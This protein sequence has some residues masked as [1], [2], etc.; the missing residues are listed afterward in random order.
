MLLEKP[1]DM[2]TREELR[3]KSWPADTFVDFDTG[4]DP[5]IKR[6]LDTLGDSA[7]SP[8]FIET[9]PKRGYRFIYPVN[10]ARAPAEVRVLRTM[11]WWRQP[12][13]TGL[14]VLTVLLAIAVAAN[15]SGLRGGITGCA[16]IRAMSW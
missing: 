15:V 2:I 1:G 3:H 9:L 5:A 8:R 6:L 14:V 16:R 10:G 7:D 13:A 12:W 4:L 11:G